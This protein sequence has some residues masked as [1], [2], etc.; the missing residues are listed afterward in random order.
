L[1][2]AHRRE[3]AERLQHRPEELGD[4]GLA[5]QA[6][7]D[8]AQRD[9]ELAGREVGVDMLDG[10]AQGPGA[11]D[12]VG[13][14][15]GDLGG[16]DPGDGELGRHKEEVAG[17]QSTARRH[18]GASAPSRLPGE[19]AHHDRAICVDL[20]R[21]KWAD[22]IQTFVQLRRHKAALLGCPVLNVGG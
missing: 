1:G 22:A 6:E 8:A 10:V 4:G 3:P 16:A 18:P 5:G 12:P 7:A 21:N 13:L 14:Q 19:L 11:A 2:R 20:S 17:D 15:L 9:A